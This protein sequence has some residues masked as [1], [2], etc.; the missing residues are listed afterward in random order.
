MR[1]RIAPGIG[2]VSILLAL[3]W[4]AAVCMQGGI[5]IAHAAYSPTAT[6]FEQAGVPTPEEG[7]QGPIHR[8]AS[9]GGMT[10]AQHWDL[11]PED[12]ALQPLPVLNP[13]LPSQQLAVCHAVRTLM[14]QWPLS[15]LASRTG[16]HAPPL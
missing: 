15:E 8:A 3:F 16:G 2:W 10:P 6:F 13:K 4:L 11:T 9:H 5:G 12:D 14:Y 1:Q 7:G